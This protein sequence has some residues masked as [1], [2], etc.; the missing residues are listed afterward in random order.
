EIYTLDEDIDH[1]GAGQSIE[2]MLPPREKP[3]AEPLAWEHRLGDAVPDALPL[4]DATADEVRLRGTFNMDLKEPQYRHILSAARRALRPGGSLVV[5]TLVADRPF[6][7]GLPQLPGPAGRVQRI[8]LENEPLQAVEQAGF[9]GLH[10]TKFAAGPCFEHD[11]VQMR[12]MLL[13]ASKPAPSSAARTR[14]VVYKGPFRE[15]RE[16]DGTV[17]VRGQRTEVSEETQA[18]LRQGPCAEQFLFLS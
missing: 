2:Q 6:P 12:E 9:V 13:S 16:D 3:A 11:G 14:L 4:G 7:H 8:P 18:R 17:Y 10:L 15:L 1:R 5:H